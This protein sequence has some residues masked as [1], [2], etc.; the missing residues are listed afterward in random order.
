MTDHDATLLA[1]DIAIA[2]MRGRSEDPTDGMRFYYAHNKIKTPLWAKNP[3][4]VAV[5][6]NHTFLRLK[7]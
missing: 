5:L 4:E 6:G 2:A 3:I 7:R 1:V